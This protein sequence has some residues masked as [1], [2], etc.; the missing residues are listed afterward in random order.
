MRNGTYKYKHN[1]LNDEVYV[2]A[3]CNKI[4]L[5]RLDSIN[6]DIKAFDYVG[7]IDEDK[8]KADYTLIEEVAQNCK[9]NLVYYVGKTKQATLINNAAFAIAVAKKQELRRTTHKT[10]KLI[11]ERI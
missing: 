2:K 6:G 9:W 5:H 3:Y 8:L 10:G 4:T 11:I 7:R 1:H